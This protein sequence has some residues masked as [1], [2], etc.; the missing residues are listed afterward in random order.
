LVCFGV[1][2]FARSA[3]SWSQSQ[4]PP[5]VSVPV[6]KEK[7]T[8]MTNHANGTF[9][10]KMT[11]QAADDKAEAAAV[12]RYL[13]DKQFHGPLE[14]TSKGEMLAVGTAVQGSAGYVAM[15]QVTG[16]L[17]GRKGTFALQHSGTMTRG[18]GLLVITVVPDSGTGELV[19]LAGKMQIKIADGKHFY[20]FEYTL[21]E[22][23]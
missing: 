6:Q 16:T 5:N 12:G 10:V 9:D 11:P 4:T 22:S 20:E 17:N 13:L 21:A 8:P 19:G 7:K 2:G 1:D 3:R 23:P 18:E 14:G 15:E